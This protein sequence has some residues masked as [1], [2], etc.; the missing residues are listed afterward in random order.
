MNFLFA[1]FLSH[2]ESVVSVLTHVHFFRSWNSRVKANKKLCFSSEPISIHNLKNL[3][4]FSRVLGRYCWTVDD[5][6][7]S[8]A[9]PGSSA[10]PGR[11]CS[12]GCWSC[13]WC[14]SATC[15]C[16]CIGSRVGCTLRS[17]WHIN[18]RSR[19]SASSSTDRAAGSRAGWGSPSARRACMERMNM[20]CRRDESSR[21]HRW[22]RDPWNSGR[23]EPSHNTCRSRSQRLCPPSR[24]SC[25]RIATLTVAA[26]VFDTRCIDIDYIVDT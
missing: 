18:S 25:Y 11:W 22:A 6:G 3:K 2:P 14:C 21:S 7:G 5:G 12:A 10:T 1:F 26:A 24:S 15:C 17:I 8:A 9:G 4:A 20:D 16:S 23:T 13:C 19:A